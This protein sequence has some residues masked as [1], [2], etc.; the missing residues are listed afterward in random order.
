MPNIPRPAFRP[1]RIL[2][3][4]A[5]AS[6]LVGAAA[7]APAAVHHDDVGTLSVLVRSKSPLT[8]DT[9]AAIG[10]YAARVA[11]VWPEIDAM[12][13]SIA[14]GRLADLMSDPLVD[15]VEADLRG[16]APGLDADLPDDLPA[17]PSAIVPLIDPAGPIETWNLDL[18]DAADGRFDGTGV[19]V[20]VLDSG[21]PQNWPD[22]LP[23][24]SV[25]TTHAAG[26]GAQ[27][28]GDFHNSVLAVHGIGGHLGLY[29]HGLAV[30]SVIV[31]FP[32]DFGLVGGAAPGATILPIRVLNQFNFGWFSWFTAG[33]LHVG[34]LKAEGRIPGPLVI[35]FS[36]QAV[37]GSEILSDAIDFAID[38]GVLF[39][40][41][42]GNFGPAPGSIAFPGRLRRSITVG[43][44]GWTGEGSSERW[45]FDDVPERDPGQVYVAG[46]SGREFSASAPEL[47][48]VLAPGSFVFGEWLAG[49]GY[50]EGRQVAFDPISEF[51]FGTSF[52]APHVAG[53]VA[54]MLQKN[55]ALT[56]AQAESLLRDNALPIAER[57]D[58]VSTPIQSV[59]GWMADATGAGLAQGAATV[60]ATPGP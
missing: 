48:D 50:S 20:A 24:G 44:A 42:A 9:V 11:Y 45:F 41:I 6:L 54:R 38:R 53:I 55:P 29:P 18:A 56:Q 5:A 25:D 47:I 57:P 27:G 2:A 19:T 39:V 35:N 46:F 21:L 28:A 3:I 34:R 33:I 7:G 10:S 40:T 30:S 37:S 43:A 51:I 15:L 49:P 4:G 36:I 22:F 58:G 26:F 13:L 32:S 23:H 31:G 12:A 17:P 59:R 8:R 1:V 60:E 14:P 16:Q 52:S